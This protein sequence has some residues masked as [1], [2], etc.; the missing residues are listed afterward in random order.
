MRIFFEMLTTLIFFIHQQR[1]QLIKNNKNTALNFE[2]YEISDKI[3]SF[4]IHSLILE[5]KL[6]M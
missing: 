3:S 2:H 1:I 5:F 4:L 6:M